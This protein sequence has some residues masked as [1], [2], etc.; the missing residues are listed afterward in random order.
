MDGFSDYEQWLS[1]Q[2]LSANTINQRLRF[3]ER[4][5]AAWGTFDLEPAELASW[6]DGFTGWTRRTYYSHLHSL[7]LWLVE[8]GDVS[9]SPMP[10]LRR[11]RTPRPR[12]NPLTSEET[13]RVLTA[14]DD[15]RLL[16]WLTLGIYAGLRAHE[17]AKIHGRDVTQSALYVVGKGGQGASV[18]THPLIWNLAQ[19]YPR[20]GYWFPSPQRDREHVSASLVGQR[21][22]DHFRA[23][24]LSGSIH[25]TR[26]TYGTELLRSGANIR[27][28]Q[29]LLRHSSLTSTEHYLG[30]TE[31]EKRAAILRLAA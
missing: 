28:V 14:A 24:G 5:H 27:I 25:R 22:R 18:P 20:A 15:A 13:T 9:E 6:L 23:Y 21:V 17:I 4:R 7:Y 16:A 30:I 12:P 8:R 26:A 3:A 29:E 1:T 2:H 19:S 31:E 10:A 11:G